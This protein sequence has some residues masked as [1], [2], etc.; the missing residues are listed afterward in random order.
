MPRNKQNT[1]TFKNPIWLLGKFSEAHDNKP[2]TLI[3]THYIEKKPLN[4]SVNLS[5]VSPVMLSEFRNRK[6]GIVILEE[7]PSEEENQ[8]HFFVKAA[9]PLFA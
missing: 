6:F 1:S 3:C 8:T 9:V 4:I 7:S 2:H 5:Y